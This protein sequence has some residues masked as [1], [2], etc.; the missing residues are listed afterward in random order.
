M[1][2]KEECLKMGG[3][4]YLMM[5]NIGDKIP[6]YDYQRCKHCGQTQKRKHPFIPPV[7]TTDWED[8]E[9]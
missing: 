1:I 2:S 5:V 8:V 4:C 9:G 3:H 6:E 7:F